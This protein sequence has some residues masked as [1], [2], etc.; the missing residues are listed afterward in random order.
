MNKSWP[1]L[2]LG[3]VLMPVS[4]AE[5]VD[6]SKGYRLL[7][8]RLEGRG[9]FLREAVLGSQISATTLF[10]V[11]AGDFIYSRLFAWRGAFG[12]VSP[13]LDGCYVSGEFP[14]FISHAN[15]IDLN[16]LFYWFRLPTTLK[17]VA[18]DCTGST[19]LTRNRFKEDFF[20][21]LE[22]P[23][24]P[25]PEQRRIVARI[26]Q[27]AAKI[28]EARKLR[29]HAIDETLS[30]PDSVAKRILDRLGDA[31]RHPI[32]KLADVQGGIQKGPHRIPSDNPTRYLTVAHVQRN[33]ILTTDP[34]YFE[35]SPEEMER[36]RLFAG[37]V[38]VIE[39]NG[40]AEQIGRTALFR[41][42]IKDCVH[43]NH[44]IRI[45]ADKEQLDPEFLNM[46]INSP[47]G[48]DEVR[49]RSR[50]TSGLR[51][52]SVGRI[53]QIEVP[54]PPLI[55]QKRCVIEFHAVKAQTERLR[56]DQDIVRR[57]LDALLPSILDKA[58][59]GELL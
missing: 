58:F 42:E 57:E 38:L 18:A 35:V 33:R 14:A 51:S 2:K 44:V 30:L 29:I 4:R 22:I 28:D 8:I 46:F 15:K 55:Q 20:L 23:L 59:K 26:D 19:P 53:K 5:K 40:S 36:W 3:E 6:P 10:R 24:P 7:G 16:F 9:P 43:Q 11:A 17:R 32:G 56:Q 31:A 45:R 48:Q 27:L 25:L 1:T 50:T 52:L 41:G 49:T 21:R 37:D 13:E 47:V 39:G 34:R 54:V 12:V